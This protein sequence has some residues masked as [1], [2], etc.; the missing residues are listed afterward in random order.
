MKKAIFLAIFTC[1]FLPAFAS[2]T[3]SQT[4]F[5]DYNPQTENNFATKEE[6]YRDDSK[7][8]KYGE[9][10]DIED[11]EDYGCKYDISGQL[12][13]W[14]YKLKDT[15]Q[16]KK[17]KEKVTKPSTNINHLK[18]KEISRGADF[19]C[20]LDNGD[21]LYCWGHNDRGQLGRKTKK[22][23][24]DVPL[25]IP[26][27]IK[28]KKIYTKAHYACA[29]DGNSHAYCWGDG[30]FGEVGNGEKGIFKTP[31]KVKTEKQFSHLVMATTYTC[32]VTKDTNEIYCWGKGVKGNSSTSNLD[33]SIPIKI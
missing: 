10:Y 25:K 18:I 12:R 32:G 5:D 30:T 27:E 4:F 9:N 3:F 33:S 19:N 15:S 31:Q 7:L 14:K 11:A 17:S 2:Y 24:I 6:D 13:C 20:A 1:M 29:L 26:T 23:H 16:P 28:F 21:D 8:K 22:E